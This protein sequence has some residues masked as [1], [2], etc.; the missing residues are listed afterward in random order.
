MAITAHQVKELLRSKNKYPINTETGKRIYADSFYCEFT[1]PLEIAHKK[2]RK[3]KKKGF[4][5]SF[6]EYLTPSTPPTD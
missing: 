4:T 5:G 3:A 2:W 1:Y 6:E